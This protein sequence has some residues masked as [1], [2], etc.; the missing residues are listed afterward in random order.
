MT[1]TFTLIL[2][3]I[4]AASLTAQD[5][6]DG[7]RFFTPVFAGEVEQTD[8]VKF[9]E[10]VQPTIINPN[11]RQEL[12]LTFFDAP[13]DPA[14]KRPLMI[15]AFGGAFVF[16]ARQSGDITALC[17]YFAEHGYATAAI[18]YRL[19]PGLLVNGN[20]RDG[21]LAVIKAMH[22]VK[23]AVRF[24]RADAAGDNLYKIDTDN[25]F[26]GGV[27]AGAVAANHAAYLDDFSELPSL[28]EPSDTAN[29]GGLEGLSGNP[30]FS[31]EVKGVIN[32][33]G[34]IGDSSWIETG[35]PAL[36]SMHG[37]EDQTVPYGIDTVRL[38]GLDLPTMGSSVMHV[39]A[40]NVDVKEALY[41]FKG[42]DHV[43]FVNAVTGQPIQTYM[44]STQ[45]FIRRQVGE[46]ICGP[47]SS[48]QGEQFADTRVWPQPMSDLVHIELNRPVAGLSITVFDIQGKK[49]NL[50]T[51]ATTNTFTLQRGPLTA[52]LYGYSI[53]D[54]KQ[55]VGRGIIAVQ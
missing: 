21:T 50:E 20:P 28:L 54:R 14:V 6:C 10:N 36:F 55:V 13:S 42:A 2:L 31:S 44:D 27:S 38:F 19:S 5:L 33:C 24:F 45:D 53:H 32:L 1:K 22:D 12:F 49:V 37:D 26:I 25:I 30:G 9:G 23:A 18:D 16:G 29:I 8:N 46:F 17:N 35:E 41:T 51:S 47:I 52:G 3:L 48:L 34:A 40:S 15:L 7:Q 43:P 4:I 39:R 11:A